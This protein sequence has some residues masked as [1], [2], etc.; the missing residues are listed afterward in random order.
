MRAVPLLALV[1]LAAPAPA[2]DPLADLRAQLVALALPAAGD[3]HAP[4][5]LAAISAQRP[6]CWPRSAATAAGPT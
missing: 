5:V 6:G 2:P 1:A 4:A 3:A